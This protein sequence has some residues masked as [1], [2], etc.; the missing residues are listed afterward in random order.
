MTKR[1][2]GN[3][4]PPRGTLNGNW[5]VRFFGVGIAL[6]LDGKQPAT[7]GAGPERMHALMRMV[8]SFMSDYTMRRLR[9]KMRCHEEASHVAVLNLVTCQNVTMS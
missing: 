9:V 6:R 3:P 8:D 7:G 1:S 5:E 2:K 4:A